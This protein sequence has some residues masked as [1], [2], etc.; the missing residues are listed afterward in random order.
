MD[1][2]AAEL[3]RVLQCIDMNQSFD[4]DVSPS[5]RRRIS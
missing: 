1:A 5:R 2:Q 3:R 4:L